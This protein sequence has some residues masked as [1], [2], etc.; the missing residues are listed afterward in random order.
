MVQK[1][2]E[3]KRYIIINIILLLIILTL[4]TYIYLLIRQNKE[5]IITGYEHSVNVIVSTLKAEKTN[6]ETQ[7]LTN[8]TDY[9]VV[10][11][12]GNSIINEKYNFQEV[13][14]NRYYYNQ[15]NDNAKLIYDSI[16]KNLSN[17]TSE[18]YQIKLPNEVAN[19]L[20]YSDGDSMLDKN[21]Q[22]AWDALSL[23]RVDIFFIDISK[24]NL[25]IKKMSYV[26]NVSYSLAIVPQDERGYLADGLTDESAVNTVL[27][28]VKINRDNIVNSV[29]GDTYNKIL[30]VHDWIIENLEYSSDGQNA[31]AYNL[32][33]AFIEKSA[34]CEGYAEAFKYIL[35]ELEIPCL[36]VC[37]TATN[38]EEI[39]ESHEWNY[40][41]LDEKW[42]A[43]DATWD[44][45]I[46]RGIGYITNSTKHKYF[47]QGSK[48]MNENHVAK[49]NITEV[50]QKF[51]YPELEQNEYKK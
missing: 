4:M 17:M 2:K 42:Y 16:E 41:Q 50:G 30:Q 14:N 15:L 5:T 23:D 35:D 11:I 46:L 18:T 6:I 25:N 47:L 38:S 33:G 28:T 39:T 3:E 1:T 44:D 20:K 32:Y 49:G 27:N 43:V 10:P 51:E 19:V 12:E 26:N 13:T 7:T 37:G 40:V 48:T 34:V 31:N 21:F 29:S 45:P 22:S 36:L 9:L 8:N 24:I